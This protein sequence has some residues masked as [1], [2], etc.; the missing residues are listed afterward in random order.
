MKCEVENVGLLPK[1]FSHFM[2]NHA[3]GVLGDRAVYIALKKRKISQVEININQRQKRIHCK[4]MKNITLQ[5]LKGIENLCTQTEFRY[6]NGREPDRK[7]RSLLRELRSMCVHVPD[8]KK[9]EATVIR[10]VFDGVHANTT[11]TT[12][13]VMMV[14]DR[15]D[16]RSV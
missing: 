14:S 10:P 4:Y 1:I 6:E 12:V 9:P 8:P 2:T 5:E 11:S 13:T 7:F 16:T 3:K 15:A